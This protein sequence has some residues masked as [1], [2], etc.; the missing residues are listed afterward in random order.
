MKKQYLSMSDLGRRGVDAL[1]CYAFRSEE[2]Q[3][4]TYCNVGIESYI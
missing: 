2:G 4:H 1:R 3:F